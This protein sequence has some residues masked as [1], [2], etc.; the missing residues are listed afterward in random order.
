M[1]LK[2][3]ELIKNKIVMKVDKQIGDKNKTV[4]KGPI[5]MIDAKDDTQI[6]TETKEL[7]KNIM[8]MKESCG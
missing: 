8:V 6:A 4:D 2:T 7:I 1:Q 5:D 3:K